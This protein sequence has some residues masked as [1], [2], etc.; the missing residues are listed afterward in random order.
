[1]SK[2]GTEAGAMFKSVGPGERRR[3]VRLENSSITNV[4]MSLA[5]RSEY[6]DLDLLDTNDSVGT[7]SSA[8]LVSWARSVRSPVDSDD[9]PRSIATSQ[10]KRLAAGGRDGSDAPSPGGRGT[11]QG[12]FVSGEQSMS[13]L[14][15]P[16][17]VVANPAS[18]EPPMGVEAE[19]TLAPVRTAVDLYPAAPVGSEANASQSLA[20]TEPL[21]GIETITTQSPCAA[22]PPLGTEAKAS[23]SGTGPE[24]TTPS[25]AS[26]VEPVA[27][28][29]VPR[30]WLVYGPR[31]QLGPGGG[32]I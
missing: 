5:E 22:E 24:S 32:A 4:R 17:V 29:D 23:Q 26:T 19:G 12:V 27:P 15:A 7:S 14:M 21:G 11:L 30:C 9:D 31:P 18:S 28:S 6:Q 8:S 3:L 16:E 20:A 25:L 13:Q 2:R 1:M 10:C